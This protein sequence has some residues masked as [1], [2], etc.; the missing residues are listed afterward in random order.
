MVYLMAVLM[1]LTMVVGCGG[2]ATY[3]PPSPD[4]GVDDGGEDAACRVHLCDDSWWTCEVC[5]CAGTTCTHVPSSSNPQKDEL[6]PV[7]GVC[8]EDLRCSEPCPG[9]LCLEAI[10]DGGL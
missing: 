10:E 8:G 6:S 1:V 5:T 3:E 2:V 9:P 7:V 4:A